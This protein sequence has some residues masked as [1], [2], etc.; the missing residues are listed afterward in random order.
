MF[1]LTWSPM[2]V[3]SEIFEKTSTS[4][5]HLKKDLSNSFRGLLLAKWESGDKNSAVFIV[6]F[7]KFRS[8]Y[9]DFTNNAVRLFRFTSL[10]QIKCLLLIPCS[11]KIKLVQADTTL[12]WFLTHFKVLTLESNSFFVNWSDMSV[13]WPIY[14][15]TQLKQKQLSIE[16]VCIFSLFFFFLN[17][18]AAINSMY[19]P[20]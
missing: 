13:A 18:I 5:Q 20:K 19:S 17:D 16:H 14:T 1:L 2:V 7:T 4:Y 8:W 11:R 12:I 15:H 6:Y 3:A 10:L 9:I